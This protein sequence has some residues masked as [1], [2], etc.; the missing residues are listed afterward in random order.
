MALAIYK[1]FVTPTFKTVQ[2]PCLK[3]T[4]K[5]IDYANAIRDKYT[6]I[7][8]RKC[9]LMNPITGQNDVNILTEK[10][11]NYVMHPSMIESYNW[12]NNH[13]PRCGCYLQ[14]VEETSYCTNEMCGFKKNNE[15][16]HK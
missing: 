1:K 3:G 16:W 14:K 13:C 12:I 7:F 11:Q 8:I 4:P 6:N 5:Q 15:E 10:F 2:L 9:Q